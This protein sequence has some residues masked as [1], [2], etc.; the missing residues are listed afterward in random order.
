MTS[1]G[2]GEKGKSKTVFDQ[3]GQNVAGS[4]TNIGNVEGGIGQIGNTI[5]TGGGDYVGG[6]VTNVG[7]DYVGGDSFSGDFRGSNVNIKSN[8]ENVTQTVGALPQVDDSVKEELQQLLLQL[9]DTLQE[10]PAENAA[11]AE[12]VSEATTL[13]VDAAAEEEPNKT[14]VE[15]LGAGLLNA[16]TTLTNELPDVVNITSKI[17]SIAGVIA[18]LAG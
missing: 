3:T 1:E 14:M 18:G 15:M 7:G 8:L 13:L 9:N 16:A 12:K 11:E 4:Q 6:S 10:A 2:S 17:V 5:N